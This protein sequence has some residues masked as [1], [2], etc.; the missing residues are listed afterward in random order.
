MSSKSG[1]LP[2]AVPLAAGRATDAPSASRPPFATPSLRAA[3]ALRTEA[4]R[5]DTLEVSPEVPEVATS[6]PSTT[7]QVKPAPPCSVRTI[8]SIASAS[9]ARSATPS[10][11][12]KRSNSCTGPPSSAIASR[13]TPSLSPV[14]SAS[15]SGRLA[16][17]P[18]LPAAP[19][20][21][22]VIRSESA[23]MAATA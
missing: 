17:V 19:C 12:P 22:T 21:S 10:P 1:S 5:N 7:A 6:R 14:A 11:S 13:R 4:R 18:L 2:P 20:A 16:E 15:V 23:L 3:V 9:A 8:A